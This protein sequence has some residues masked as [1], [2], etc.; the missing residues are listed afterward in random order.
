M[1]EYEEW[2]EFYCVVCGEHSD[3]CQGHGEI[4][5]PDGYAILMAHDNDGHSKC[6]PAGCDE[7]VLVKSRMFDA[8]GRLTNNYR[9]SEYDVFGPGPE[10]GDTIGTSGLYSGGAEYIEI[11]YTL[12]G[13]YVGSVVERTNHYY[14]LETYCD[15]VINVQGAFSSEWLILKIGSTIPVAMYDEIMGLANY[16]I[17]DDEF[18]STLEN[19]IENEDWRSFGKWELRQS[20]TPRVSEQ[21]T[22]EQLRTIVCTMASALGEN[23]M[24]WEI[25]T[26]TNGFYHNTE[27]YAK[28]IMDRYAPAN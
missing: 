19:D 3:Y 6:N 5:D 10:P 21:I 7:I 16:P 12:W 23:P 25:E 28:A 20:L 11:P 27:Q 2:P 13:D 9:W 15:Y 14:F 26:A 1:Y 17:I 4:G 22:D 24:G 8:P 18:M